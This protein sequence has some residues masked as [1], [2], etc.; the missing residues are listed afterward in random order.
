MLCGK[1]AKGGRDVDDYIYVAMNM[2]W[3]ELAFEMPGLPERMKWHRFVDT[4]A[5]P[6]ADICE[7]GDEQL[8]RD[9]GGFAVGGRSVVI[10]VGKWN[11]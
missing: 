4:S 8:L 6:P 9:Q 10:L 7:P 5:P 3:E 2:Y 1:H 11:V